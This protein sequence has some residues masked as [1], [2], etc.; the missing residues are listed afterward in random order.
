MVPKSFKSPLVYSFYISDCLE[1]LLFVTW[2]IKK[3]YFVYMMES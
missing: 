3:P 1:E 2:Q